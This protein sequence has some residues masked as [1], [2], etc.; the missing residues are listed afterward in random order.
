MSSRRIMILCALMATALS[1]WVSG[2]AGALE[3]ETS[4]LTKQPIGE[5]AV[6]GRLS[7]DLHA[8]FMVSRTYDKDTVLNW[9]NCGYSGGGNVTQVG[10]DFGDFG[11][12][13]PFKERDEKYPHAV[14]IDKVRAVRF[15]GN[16]FMKGKFEVEKK[17]AGPQ[18]MAIEVWVRSDNTSKGEVILGWQS[19]DGKE[20]SAPLAFPEKFTGSDKW[21]HIVVNCTPE[22][23]DW[24]LD[25]VKVSSGKRNTII[26]EGHVM[27]LGGASAAN[28][29]FKGD[30]VAVRLHDEAMTDEEIEH[31]F[32]GGVMLGTEMH[33]IGRAHV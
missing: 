15:D 28:P 26:K 22:K 25:G 7:I 4:L 16:D 30:L 17:I 10:G 5:L 31:N 23:E 3:K 24:Y 1:A 20:T 11:F 21:R 2:T 29:S 27:V 14:T 12:Q 32:K 9:Y 18:N 13:V 33:E 19:K 8:E 6:A